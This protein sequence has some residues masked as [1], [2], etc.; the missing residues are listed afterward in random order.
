M[1]ADHDLCE[2]VK[3]NRVELIESADID[4]LRQAFEST[5]R[6]IGGTVRVS[7]DNGRGASGSSTGASAAMVASA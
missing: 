4:R 2:M 3:A 7:G 1:G 5:V 6:K